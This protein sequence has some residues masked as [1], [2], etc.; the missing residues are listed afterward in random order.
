MIR[1]DVSKAFLRVTVTSSQFS[2][3]I[4][5]YIIS[6]FLNFICH[7]Q[8]WSLWWG[9][10]ASPFY[11]DHA[12]FSWHGTDKCRLSSMKHR[13]TILINTTI[14]LKLKVTNTIWC[15]LSLYT[16][17]PKQ[18]VHALNAWDRCAMFWNWKCSSSSDCNGRHSAQLKKN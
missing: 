8:W 1:L 4:F 14:F 3:S 6:S 15:R 10:V 16:L 12:M 2:I 11:L 13:E 5:D 7:W 18:W 17:E 9:Y